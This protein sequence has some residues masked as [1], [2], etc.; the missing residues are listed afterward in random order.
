M[1]MELF[2]VISGL[3]PCGQNYL[4]FDVTFKKETSGGDWKNMFDII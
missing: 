2:H 4:I 1:K 3:T